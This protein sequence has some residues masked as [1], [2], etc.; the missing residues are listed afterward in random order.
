LLDA[1]RAKRENMV[2]GIATFDEVVRKLAQRI[3]HG[4]VVNAS[5]VVAA[6]Q[7][8]IDA[9]GRPPSGKSSRAMVTG[10]AGARQRLVDLLSV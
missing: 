10:R 5:R 1:E 9:L 6:R 3:G 8:E 2:D 7:R 4:K